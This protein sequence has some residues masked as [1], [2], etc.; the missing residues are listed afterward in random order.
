MTS[1]QSSEPRLK[2]LEGCYLIQIGG[3]GRFD[4]PASSFRT[5]SDRFA[6]YY[7]ESGGMSNWHELETEHFEL[8][9]DGYF[10]LEDANSLSPTANLKLFSDLLESHG[11]RRAHEEISGGMFN[12]YVWNKQSGE[13]EVLNDRLGLVPLYALDYRGNTLLT[14]NQL[15]FQEFCELDRTAIFEFLKFGYLPVSESIF[16]GVKRLEANSSWVFDKKGKQT[17]TRQHKFP[18]YP[19]RRKGI[20][21]VDVALRSWKEAFIHFFQRIQSKNIMVGFSGGYNTRY[22]VS[23][24]AHQDPQLINYAVALT[25]ENQLAKSFVKRL[26][27][28]MGNDQIPRNPI[29]EYAERFPVEFKTLTS[30]EHAHL[31][32]LSHRVKI[33][34]PEHYL[35]GYLGGFALS[36]RLYEDEISGFGSILRYLFPA[37]ERYLEKIKDTAAI[38]DRIYSGDLLT[39]RDSEMLPFMSKEHIDKL[40]TRIEAKLKRWEKGCHTQADL[41]E[42][43]RLMTEGRQL[44]AARP[45]ALQSHTQTLLPFAD[46]K[47]VEYAQNT[48]KVVRFA[49]GLYN[50]LLSESFPETA[51]IRIPGT[52]GKVT[53]SP[54]MYRLKNAYRETYIRDI[55][56][57]RRRDIGKN[58]RAEQYF[59]RAAKITD[60]RDIEFLENLMREGNPKMPR[61][62][63]RKI[64]ETFEE[65]SLGDHMTLRYASLLLYLNHSIS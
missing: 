4:I 12:L 25:A 54:F 46:Y 5:F 34:G 15:N 65:G 60:F 63:S 9:L 38:V 42:R 24:V 43:M 56:S 41:L 39:L 37:E 19:M 59:S 52:Y 16:T 14:N 45:L 27:L 1:P 44:L 6:L 11:Q 7:S 2:I 57:S 21:E 31:Q 58:Q 64:T 47:V 13:L 62:L 32:H 61:D 26:K 10:Y 49:R 22:I 35:D 17:K 36:D 30:L 29:E 40:G 20:P 33:T 53:D 28:L 51:H 55:L 50:E 48:P 8:L 18:A 3:Q 23:Q